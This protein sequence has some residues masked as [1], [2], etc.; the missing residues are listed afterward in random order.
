MFIYISTEI[1]NPLKSCLIAL[2]HKFLHSTQLQ[3]STLP[4]P[5]LSSSFNSSKSTRFF[6]SKSP[7]SL[8]PSDPA[9]PRAAPARTPPRPLQIR[10]T[11]PPRLQLQIRH[12]FI[13]SVHLSVNPLNLSI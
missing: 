2:N 1:K 12:C 7:P 10:A 6:H 3:S 9:S 4:L 13:Q 11:P 5:N 8:S